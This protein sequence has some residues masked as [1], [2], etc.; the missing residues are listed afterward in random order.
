MPF[1]DVKYLGEFDLKLP[2]FLASWDVWEYWEHQRIKSMQNKLKKTDCLYEIGAE[3][4]WMT[5]LFGKYFVDPQLMCIFEPTP[6]YWPNIRQTWEANG[7]PLPRFACCSLV[8]AENKNSPTVRSGWPLE[9]DHE[10]TQARSYKYIHEHGE[11]V[12]QIKIDN[13]VGL[14]GMI[15]NAL[16]IDVEGAEVEVLAGAMNTIKQYKPLIWCSVHEDLMLRNYNRTLGDFMNVLG[17][18]NYTPHLL[19]TDHEAHYLLEPWIVG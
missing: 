10:M 2:D 18:L 16:T 11:T 12:P 19:A 1:T 5:A 3:S 8:G 9:A 6:E 17:H 7:L 4:G 15:P 13:F 14:T